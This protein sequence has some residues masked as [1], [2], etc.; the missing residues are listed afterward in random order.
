MQP[1]TRDDFD[2]E[3]VASLM[4]IVAVEAGVSVV[5]ISE[6]T[7]RRKVVTARQL[8]I[9][10]ALRHLGFSSVRLSHFLPISKSSICRQ[11]EKATE[12]RLTDNWF[13]QTSDRIILKLKA[14]A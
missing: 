12:Q 7:K 3:R 5:E 9:Y 6:H 4:E 14:A 2:A 11:H 1:Q 8:L 10:P 13:C